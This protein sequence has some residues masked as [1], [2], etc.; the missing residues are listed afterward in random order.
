MRFLGLAT[1][2][3][4]VF[5]SVASTAWS[6]SCDQLF[7]NA[8]EAPKHLGAISAGY[9]LN[10]HVLKRAFEEPSTRESV[11]ALIEIIDVV[12]TG[13]PEFLL[14]LIRQIQHPRMIGG[15]IAA[16]EQKVV[17]ERAAAVLTELVADLVRDR[18]VKQ[19]QRVLT[20]E[21]QRRQVREFLKNRAATHRLPSLPEVLDRHPSLF[22]IMARIMYDG[23]THLISSKPLLSEAQY[24]LEFSQAYD[25][26]EADFV[27]AKNL[28]DSLQK[29]VQLAVDLAPPETRKMLVL[30]YRNN[31][32]DADLILKQDAPDAIFVKKKTIREAIWQRA[33]GTL[34]DVLSDSVLISKN[35]P[36][37][38]SRG[39]A[40]PVAEDIRRYLIQLL[41][42]ESP[43][44]AFLYEMLSHRFKLPE[45]FE[46]NAMAIRQ[47]LRRR[48]IPLGDQIRHHIKELDLARRR[49]YEAEETA[50]AVATKPQTLQLK[51][52]GERVAQVQGNLVKDEAV[53]IIRPEAWVGSANPPAAME[54]AKPLA[55]LSAAIPVDGT[56][57]SFR[58]QNSTEDNFVTIDS[59]VVAELKK[60]KLSLSTWIAAFLN[61]PV[62]GERVTG[63]KLLHGTRTDLWEI[64]LRGVSL[65][66]IVS[67]DKATKTWRW[68][69]LV[70]HERVVQYFKDHR[71]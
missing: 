15:F 62:G 8:L 29:K 58:F 56:R 7:A 5:L 20:V 13:K 63:V 55:T 4:V 37:A 64:R 54:S 35:G 17:S 9:R 65:R 61:G 44:F 51:Q 67:Q 10:S 69:A 6:Q 1:L 16:S 2:V 21:E 12:E 39:T 32:T 14:G 68:R 48:L 60:R 59:D 28:V 46:Y 18:D 27:T 57:Y 23:M 43:D 71:L 70:P 26:S 66:I 36:E 47:E 25:R 50:K 42:E 11:Q 41:P 31:F 49:S 52:S 34:I 33:A 22:K 38:R 53:D 3:G 30:V 45:K 19:G 40:V 24:D